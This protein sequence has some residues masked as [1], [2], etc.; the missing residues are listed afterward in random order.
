MNNQTQNDNQGKNDLTPQDVISNAA[1]FNKQFINKQL[2]GPVTVSVGKMLTV[3]GQQHS[4]IGILS[5]ILG[6]SHSD[7]ELHDMHNSI[8]GGLVDGSGTGRKGM[9]L[10]DVLAKITEFIYQQ[11]Q[12]I[13]ELIVKIS[14][15]VRHDENS[16][17]PSST[18]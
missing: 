4:T 6:E 8:F 14:Q 2:A 1:R 11:N 13:Q 15:N 3:M 7:K 9:E 12:Q 16:E 10:E 18:K 17:K 5:N